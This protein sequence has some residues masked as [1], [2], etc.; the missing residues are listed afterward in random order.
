MTV[1]AFWR[2]NLFRIKFAD[3]LCRFLEILIQI[4]VFYPIFFARKLKPSQSQTAAI[5]FAAGLVLAL[6]AAPG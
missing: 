2:I 6:V 4:Y 3:G 5:A 1:A